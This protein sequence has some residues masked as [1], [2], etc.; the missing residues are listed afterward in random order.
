MAGCSLAPG[1]RLIMPAATLSLAS[2]SSFPIFLPPHAGPRPP[3]RQTPA[4]QMRWRRREGEPA[5]GPSAADGCRP[6]MG[7]EEEEEGEEGLISMRLAL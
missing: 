6:E 5:P 1:S 4:R 7:G 2:Y 3:S